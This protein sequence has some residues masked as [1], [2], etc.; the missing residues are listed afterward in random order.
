MRPLLLLLDYRGKALAKLLKTHFTFLKSLGGFYISECFRPKS[1]LP[2][3]FMQRVI[4]RELCGMELDLM[5][6]LSVF[7]LPWRNSLS[8]VPDVRL[9]SFYL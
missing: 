4:F 5:P 2:E 9:K 1:L 8:V 6:I 3:V 7:S